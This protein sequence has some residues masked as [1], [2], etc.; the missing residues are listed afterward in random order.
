MKLF[1]ASLAQSPRRVRMFLAE[2]GLDV[3][4]VEVDIGA[5]ENLG[6]EYLAMNPR[7]LVPT[8]LLDDGTDNDE[9]MAICRYFE[10]LPPDPA[11]MGRD[12]LEKATIEMWQRRAAL[13]VLG[14]I[15]A[16]FRH[17]H[18]ARAELEVPQV[19]AWGEANRERALKGLAR[20]DQQLRQTAFL[21]GDAFSIA[22]ITALCA[23]D[24]MKLA[25]IEMPADLTA[26]KR[27]YDDVASR[28]SA[29]AGLA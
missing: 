11:L 28:P 8:L 10:E 6:A 22:D 26:L 25:R 17:L 19:P 7:G 4:R 16:S 5:A 21:A 13:D 12:P 27:W 1:D 20:L 3:P 29:K 23:I 24:M 2:K 15:A 18:P 9:S 14:P